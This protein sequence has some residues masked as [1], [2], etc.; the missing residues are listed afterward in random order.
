MF[1]MHGYGLKEGKFFQQVFIRKLCIVYYCMNDLFGI[2][3]YN[4]D[5][6]GEKFMSVHFYWPFIVSSE[7]MKSKYTVYLVL[8]AFLTAIW[9]V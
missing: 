5:V 7:V 4:Y 8:A 2:S 3:V 9:F 6:F 1:I